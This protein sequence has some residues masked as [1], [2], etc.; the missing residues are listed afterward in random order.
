MRFIPRRKIFSCHPGIICERLEERIVLNATVPQAPDQDN[1]A[2]NPDQTAG[3]GDGGDL[4]GS[5]AADSAGTPEV[6]QELTQVFENDLNVILV[7]NA[8]DAIEALSDRAD[9]ATTVIVY[10]EEKDDFASIG[11][12]L[13]DLAASW[14]RKIGGIAILSHGNDGLLSI[15]SDNL[16]LF[17][18]AGYEPIFSQISAL[19]A[20]DAQIHLF[21]CSIAADFF[22]QAMIDAI[23]G[24]TG[25][26]VFASTNQTG[27]A[28]GDWILEYATDAAI[29]MTLIV[30]THTA[31]Q[32]GIELAAA[33]PATENN[34]ATALDGMLYFAYNDGE[35]G[36]ELWRSDGTASGTYMVVD[37]NTGA[38][39]SSPTE[40]TAFNGVL[41]FSATD[42]NS[43]S[44]HGTELW[45]SDGTA[46]GTY[47]VA[48]INP[49]NVSS[50]P[51]NFFEANGV[52]YFA[53]S[54]G[55]S[56]ADHG[57]ELWRSDGTTAGTY[58]VADINAGN[59]GSDPGNFVEMNGI[60][61]FSASD[62]NSA[63]DHGR[64]L[65]RTDGTGAGTWMV[66]DINLGNLGSDPDNLTDVNG[67]LYFSASDGNSAADHGR[68]L[69]RSDGTGAG[70]WMVA[71]INPGNQSSNPDNL[72]NVNGVLYFSAS[73]GTS[74]ADHGR[75]LW[76]SDGTGAGTWM[77]ADI[78]TGNQGSNPDNLTAVNGVL[79]FS[80]DDGIHG[81]ELWKSDGTGGGTLMAADINPGP[82]GSD[83]VFFKNYDGTLIFA[84]DDGVHGY[85]P[86]MSDGTPGGTSL[87]VDINPMGSSFPINFG[88][89]NPLFFMADAGNGYELWKSDGTAE[90]TVR[91]SDLTPDNTS[92]SPPPVPPPPPHANDPDLTGD[93]VGKYREFGGPFQEGSVPAG[94][95]T[96]IK[97]PNL[98]GHHSPSDSSEYG[99]TR[100]TQDSSTGTHG[101]E[102]LEAGSKTGLEGDRTD[103]SDPS[104][105]AYE[106]ASDSLFIPGAIKVLVLSNGDY[107]IVTDRFSLVI[108]SNMWMPPMV[109]WYLVTVSE[110][111]YRQ[112]ALPSKYEAMIWDFLAYLNRQ[113]AK[114][115]GQPSEV[116]LRLAWQWAE[117]RKQVLK[118]HGNREVLPWDYFQGLSKALTA[119]YGKS[120]AGL[121]DY[122]SAL[123]AMR[124]NV[125]NLSIIPVRLPAETLGTAVWK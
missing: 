60:L 21:G 61:Y 105:H 9:T 70:T 54:D 95:F 125:K 34:W 50:N 90:G 62:G 97:G 49:G 42:G 106:N 33:Y 75:E 112:G 17:N 100:A 121:I 89:V 37:I 28:H 32:S 26:D 73:D 31:S 84:A 27:G 102:S 30:D 108:P 6:P 98:S 111:R 88:R 104:E 103:G 14:D 4:S 52:L 83:P 91:V 16:T 123:T 76:G 117:W 22:G 13:E 68:E 77:V 47:M 85:E 119:F 55:T 44:D 43:A 87:M 18:V 35:H 79:Y 23:A 122:S 120:A 115:D 116:T 82:D 86:W 64:E 72:T 66:A 118:E 56:A 124:H 53:A 69:W 74:A 71:D 114:D 48:D 80:A 67:V 59:L 12:V 8:L 51:G 24:Y 5:N 38:V 19:L 96:T 39:G 10:D 40:L 94:L 63:S 113:Q 92:P 107:S 20:D 29:T 15:G 57:R 25:A 1:S 36:T 2:G 3:T 41:Y 46:A 45:R 110:G 78:N 93:V 58:M 99:K 81:R 101:R 65:W 109:Q 7:S 11:A